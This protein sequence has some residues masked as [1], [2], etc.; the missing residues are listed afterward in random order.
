METFDNVQFELERK[1]GQRSIRMRV[2]SDGRLVVSAPVSVSK[3][4]ILRFV[5]DNR[6][7]IEAHVGKVRAFDYSDGEAVPFH[8][9]EVPV[10]YI[11]SRG[12]SSFDGHFIRIHVA[13]DTGID[14][15]KAKLRAFMKDDTLRRGA[16]RIGFWSAKMGL[17]MPQLR[18]NNAKT[19]WGSCCKGKISISLSAMCAC[20]SDDLF[21]MVCLHEVCHLV[22]PDHQAGFHDLMDSLMPDCDERRKRLGSYSEAHSVRNLL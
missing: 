2:A 16:V 22:H 10:M 20:L 7:W 21:D 19:R 14:A 1:R 11:P 3:E 18:A 15:R 6:S 17:T 13:K 4:R 12:A 5:S 9:N 8:G